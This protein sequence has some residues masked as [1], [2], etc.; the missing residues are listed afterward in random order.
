MCYVV[1]ACSV[2]VFLVVKYKKKFRRLKKG[3]FRGTKKLVFVGDTETVKKI[4]DVLW[5]TG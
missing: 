4:H 1:L 3:G 5:T 2:F